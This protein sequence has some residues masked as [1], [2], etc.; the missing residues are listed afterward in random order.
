M[1]FLEDFDKDYWKTSDRRV[2]T[3]NKKM[4]DVIETITCKSKEFNV[5]FDLWYNKCID[6][7]NSI[8]ESLLL[9]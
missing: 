4:M 7:L 6:E 9:L 2:Y 1:L 5:I 3:A 8:R